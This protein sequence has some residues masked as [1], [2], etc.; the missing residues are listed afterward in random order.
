VLFR[1]VLPTRLRQLADA[2]RTLTPPFKSTYSSPI[3]SLYV[4][5]TKFRKN[6]KSFIENSIAAVIF[7]IIFAAIIGFF[8]FQNVKIGSKRAELQK[9]LY[10][11]QAQVA[12]MSE[13]H[14]ELEEGIA[15]TQTEEY[16]EKLL[17][18]QGLYKKPGEEVVTI[19]EE[20]GEGAVGQEEQ[21]QERVWWNPFTW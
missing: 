20:E 14:G 4:M 12:E 8:L 6:R 19:L 1:F 16:Q 5:V 9:Q 2:R 7:V 18:E 13:Q 17:R 11:L 15:N 21:E 3:V 10:E